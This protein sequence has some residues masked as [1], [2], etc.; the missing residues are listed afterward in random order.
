MTAK[1]IPYVRVFLDIPYVSSQSSLNL[2]IH[3]DI[4]RRVDNSINYRNGKNKASLSGSVIDTVTYTVILRTVPVE[5]HGDDTPLTFHDTPLF[6]LL[7][8]LVHVS[9][10]NV[11]DTLMTLPLR[12]A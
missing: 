6:S 4:K 7:I 1:E 2:G 12:L 11:H 3:M 10:F 9:K 5:C 8:L